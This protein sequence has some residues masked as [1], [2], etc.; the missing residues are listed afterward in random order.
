MNYLLMNKDNPVAEFSIARGVIGD[1][2]TLSRIPDQKLPIGFK[3]IQ[4]WIDNRKGS[5][6]NAHLKKIMEVCG[7][8]KTEGF[9]R[10]ICG[11]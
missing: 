3:D 9:L 7:C 11:T 2:Y 1:V 6:H 5:K 4:N 8:E 10:I